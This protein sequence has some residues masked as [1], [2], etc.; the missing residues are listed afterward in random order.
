MSDIKKVKAKV[1]AMLLA[2]RREF[3]SKAYIPL[4]V[5]EIESSHLATNHPFNACEWLMLSHRLAKHFPELPISQ[6]ILRFQSTLPPYVSATKQD[7]KGVYSN[8]LI[9]FPFI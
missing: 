3:L 4:S 9:F 7:I 6:V 5:K 8:Q 2:L 1:L